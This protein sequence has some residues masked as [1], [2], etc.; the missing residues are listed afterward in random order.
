MDVRARLPR[1][2]LWLAGLVSV[3][4]TFALV[5]HFDGPGVD[6]HAY[7]LAWRGEMYKGAP[8]TYDAFLY[9]PAFAQ[10]IWPLTLAPWPVF[11]LTWSALGCAALVWLV[12]GCRWQVA[13]PLLLIGSHE[14]VAG[15]INWLL[16][17]VVV[18][19]QRHPW[20]WAVPLLTKVVPGVGPL[21]FLVRR[22]WRALAISLGATILI[23]TVSWASAPHL[24]Q[25]WLDLL[26]ESSA[27]TGETVGGPFLPPLIYRVPVVVALVVWAARTGR[28]WVLPVAMLLASP[29]AGPYFALLL[30]IPRLR[31]A[32][33]LAG[34]GSG[35]GG[36]RR[37]HQRDDGLGQ[38]D[39]VDRVRDRGLG[40]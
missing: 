29:V 40:T 21:W 25:Q 2:L 9:S 35:G 11:A 24:W 8:A 3:W 33:R 38:L 32:D 15:N 10:A 4:L 17:L 19:G 14:V 26:L 22:E 36:H 18:L 34:L 20:L 30:A 5:V 27:S 31:E 13:V 28:S 12:R 16:A 37:S 39:G 7:W 1:D 6:S 23:V